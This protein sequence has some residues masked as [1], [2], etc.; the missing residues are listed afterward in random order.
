[1]ATT[2]FENPG[3]ALSFSYGLVASQT[4]QA[5]SSSVPAQRN[6]FT[7]VPSGTSVTMGSPGLPEEVVIIN[8]GGNTLT[9]FPPVGWS[10]NNGTVNAS[11]SIDNGSALTFISGDPNESSWWTR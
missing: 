6:V 4:T 10:F 3:V 5:G 2:Q 7:S 11:I 9:V 8:R 1:M